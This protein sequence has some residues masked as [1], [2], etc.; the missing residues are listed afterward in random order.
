MN[1]TVQEDR[2]F[3]KPSLI[4]LTVYH[5]VIAI[6]LGYLLLEIWPPDAD[7]GNQSITL[8]G[9]AVTFD[10]TA[11]LRLISIVLVVGALGSYIQAATSFAT[12]AGNQKAY[13]SWTWWYILRP[14]IG[15]ALA[16][17][18]YFVIRGGLLSAGAGASDLNVFG[19]S[20]VAGLVGMFSRQA[21]DKLAEVF[22][23][24]FSLSNK[25]QRKDKL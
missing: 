4:A 21:T 14:F 8:F 5:L 11:D 18:F 12:Y 2:R 23:N 7:A 10:A 19:V 1:E 24:L 15:A 6:A 9:E 16:V 22:E 17:I 3:N 20:A 25:D 13:T